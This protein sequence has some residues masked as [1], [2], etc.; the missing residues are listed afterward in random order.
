MGDAEA[1]LAGAARKMEAVY[2][3]PFLAHAPMEPLNCTARRAR[4]MR[5]EVWASTQG[6]TRRAQRGAAASPACRRTRSKIYTKYMGGGFGRR[7]RADYIGEAVE[8]S[9]AAGVPVK[10][11]WSRE[12]DMQQ[13]LVPARPPTRISPAALDADGWPVAWTSRIACPPFGGARPARPT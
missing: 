13:D 5:C 11:T 12:D 1:A 9:K 8:V 2:E 6:Q 4:A 7:A 3:V 10:L